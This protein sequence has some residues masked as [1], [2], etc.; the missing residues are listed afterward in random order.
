MR[1]AETLS[2]AFK[3]TVVIVLDRGGELFVIRD[4]LFE[5]HGAVA[6]PPLTF[7][8]RQHLR[9]HRRLRAL[10]CLHL[11][12]HLGIKGALDVFDIEVA[13]LLAIR[14]N[15]AEDRDNQLTP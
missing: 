1:G 3:A 13:V 14:I 11:W 10:A 8:I 7:E 6:I 9:Q 12:V 2:G 4:P 5:R 15:G